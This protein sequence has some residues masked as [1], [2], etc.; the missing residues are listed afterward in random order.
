MPRS[1][2]TKPAKKRKSWKISSSNIFKDLGFTDEEATNFFVRGQLAIE[3]TN[4]II[5]RG[6][7]QRKAAQELGVSQPRIAEIMSMKLD[8][9]TIDTLLKYLDK[10]GQKVSFKVE[11]KEVA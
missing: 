8:L 1:K 5:G 3:I 7:S 9:Y 10:L 6:W 2:K 11:P 4:L